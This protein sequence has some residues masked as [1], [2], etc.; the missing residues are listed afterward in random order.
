M[1]RETTGLCIA[2]GNHYGQYNY[3][4]F[5]SRCNIC[6][7]A[8]GIRPNSARV[9][10]LFRLKITVVLRGAKLTLNERRLDKQ[11]ICHS[12]KT[13]SAIRISRSGSKAARLWTTI[14]KLPGCPLRAH[15][16]WKKQ[17]LR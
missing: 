8:R 14:L 6:G 13:E 4:E 9:A 17:E 5:I 2:S 7:D 3:G 12:K 1:A 15:G 16:R 11:M 10:A